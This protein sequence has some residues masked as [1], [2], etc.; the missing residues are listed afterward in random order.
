MK[1]ALALSGGGVRATAFHCGVLKRLAIDGLLESTTF[2]SS[3]SGG[4]LLMGLIYCHN[5][6][7]WPD[8]RRFVLN[9]LPKVRE[10]LT[11]ATLQWSYTWRSFSKPWRLAQGRAHVLANQMVRQWGISGSLQDIVEVPR[12]IVNATCYETGK[13]WRFSQPRMGDYVTKY[14]LKPV[15]PIADVIAASAA[16]PGLIGPYTI[17]SNEYKWFQITGQRKT[18]TTTPLQRYRLWDGGVY[19]NLGLEALFK[20]NGGYRDGF[21]FLIVSDASARF[22]LDTPSLI[23]RLKPG[24]RTLRLID[25]ATEQ[26]RGLRARSLVEGF[27]RG[28]CAGAYLRIGNTVQK[29]LSDVGLSSPVT[30]CLSNAAVTTVANFKTTLRRL[31]SDE[32]DLIVQH[33]FEVA[34]ATL[35]TRVPKRFRYEE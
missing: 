10:K 12:W 19:D 34:N 17:H 8:S 22:S 30:T 21:D 5:E 4:S 28:D 35:A 20:P 25:V 32:F 31:S 1:I 26:I 9:V 29:I 14:V 27:E 13:N 6:H 15:T 2:V 33:G 16:V 3:V 18:P 24:R 7:Q 11:K 23:S